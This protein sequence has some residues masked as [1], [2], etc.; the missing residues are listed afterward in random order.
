MK[1]HK[2]STRQNSNQQNSE[3]RYTLTEKGKR[4]IG[5]NITAESLLLAFEMQKNAKA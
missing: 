5:G 4:F 2:T 1:H 3:A